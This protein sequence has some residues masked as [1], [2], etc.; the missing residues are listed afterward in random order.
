MNYLMYCC[1]FFSYN[2][3]F[4]IHIYSFIVFASEYCEF[5]NFE[6]LFK[7]GI[8]IDKTFYPEQ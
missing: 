1:I 5:R 3:F 6:T 8:V 4:Y 2:I 7:C